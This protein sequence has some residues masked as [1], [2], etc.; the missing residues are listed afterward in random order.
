MNRP[1]SH[2]LLTINNYVNCPSNFAF[3]RSIYLF[4]PPIFEEIL[5]RIRSIVFVWSLLLNFLPSFLPTGSIW[6]GVWS[7]RS[8]DWVC[9]ANGFLRWETYPCGAEVCPGDE[10][11]FSLVPRL[12][13]YFGYLSS[14]SVKSWALCI[15]YLSCLGYSYSLLVSPSNEERTFLCHPLPALSS[16]SATFYF[17]LS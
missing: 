17:R 14:I 6:P 3:G 8:G 5:M 16:V 12:S 13:N 11:H 7:H 2:K 9:E 10:V 4:H 1:Y 15:S